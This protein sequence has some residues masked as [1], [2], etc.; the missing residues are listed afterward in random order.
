LDFGTLAVNTGQAVRAEMPSGIQQGKH[1]NI[2]PIGIV[3]RDLTIVPGSSG[4]TAMEVTRSNGLIAITAQKNNL[5]VHCGRANST[6]TQGMHV[7]RA[8]AKSDCET[9]N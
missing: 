9:V 8:D 3:A 6:V 1:P 7:T 5:I 4:A 2:T